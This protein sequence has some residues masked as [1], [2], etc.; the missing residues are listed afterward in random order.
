MLI[1]QFTC[2]NDYH[3]TLRRRLW[4]SVAMTLLG[5]TAVVLS[6][7]VLEN[8]TDLRDFIKGFYFGAGSGLTVA[9]IVFAIRTLMLLKNPAAAKK[10]Q[11]T[12]QDEREKAIL[13]ASVGT[14]F[15]VLYVVIVAGIIISLP[16]NMTVFF[17]LCGQLFLITAT[18]LIATLWHRRHM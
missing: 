17:T 14:V 9:G 1:K 15:G 12:E 16:L 4:L 6:R 8:S 13:T 10:A 3:A 7:T 5:I 2:G 18:L 11:V